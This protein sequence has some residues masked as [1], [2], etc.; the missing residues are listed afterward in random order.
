[1]ETP[2]IHVSMRRMLFLSLAWVVLVCNALA[3]QTTVGQI[4]IT[5][6][7]MLNAQRKV[8]AHMKMDGYDGAIG[9]KLRGN[10]S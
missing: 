4:S 1:M 2:K 6:D 7:S 5:V 10:S 8:T 3:Q 9:I